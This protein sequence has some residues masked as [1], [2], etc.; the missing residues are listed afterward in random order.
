MLDCTGASRRS[1]S[2]SR[3]R[4]MS[5]TKLPYKMFSTQMLALIPF[6]HSC[7]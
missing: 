7:G 2:D 1:Q 5:R 6:F 4:E 3:Y